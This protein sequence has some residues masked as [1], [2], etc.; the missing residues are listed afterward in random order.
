ML[1][2]WQVLTASWTFVTTRQPAS[3]LAPHGT[4]MIVLD[5]VPPLDLPTS[6]GVAARRGTIHSR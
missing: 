4:Y 2:P 6:R 3:T 1:Q 5:H